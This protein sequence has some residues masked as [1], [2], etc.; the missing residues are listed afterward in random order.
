MGF[1]SGF[2]GLSFIYKIAIAIKLQFIIHFLPVSSGFRIYTHAFLSLLRV[3][4]ALP[5]VQDTSTRKCRLLHHGYNA[6]VDDSWRK[7]HLLHHE[8]NTVADDSWAGSHLVPRILHWLLTE[9]AEKVEKGQILWVHTYPTTSSRR[10]GRH[11]QSLVEIGS[12]I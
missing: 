1:N 5:T 12:E 11:V 2:K 10:R 3:V 4:Y 9:R 7:C 6:I 8:Y